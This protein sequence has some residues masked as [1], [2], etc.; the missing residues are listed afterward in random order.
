VILLVEALVFKLGMVLP[1]FKRM[2]VEEKAIDQAKNGC[3]SSISSIGTK[4]LIKTL[5]Q[6][7]H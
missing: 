4:P 6:Y 2:T 5:F 1:Y 3:A 7:V